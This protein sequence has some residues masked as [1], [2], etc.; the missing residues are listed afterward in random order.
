M[1]IV[2]QCEILHSSIFL[3]NCEDLCL[4]E[5]YTFEIISNGLSDVIYEGLGVD[6]R[7]ILQ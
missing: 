2:F 1:K 7:A 6:G 3:L 4:N 5:M